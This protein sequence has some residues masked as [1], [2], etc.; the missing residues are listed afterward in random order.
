VYDP[1]ADEW[2]GLK[3]NDP[4]Y[5]H[6]LSTDFLD[7]IWL[8]NGRTS[9][10]GGSYF[11]DSDNFYGRRTLRQYTISTDTWTDLAARPSSGSSAW[12]EPDTHEF[13]LYNG[14]PQN[15]G[16]FLYT[17]QP[18][19]T[20]GGA[21]KQY[22]TDNYLRYTIA[23][24]TWDTSFID[25]DIPDFGTA[26]HT[27]Y[28]TDPI[29]GFA[30]QAGAGAWNTTG[31]TDGFATPVHDELVRNISVND[32]FEHDDLN[33][34]IGNAIGAYRNKILIVGALN[35][36]NEVTPL[37]YTQLRD[38]ALNTMTIVQDIPVKVAYAQ[39]A[40]INDKVYIMGGVTLHYNNWQTTHLV[41]V[42]DLLSFE[43]S[44]AKPLPRG[45]AYGRAVGIGNKIYLYGG[46]H[47]QSGTLS[48]QL[49]VYDTEESE[50]IVGIE[51]LKN[52]LLTV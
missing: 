14:T 24:N 36:S 4:L 49:I 3:E 40:A 52:Y 2:P 7:K 25:S 42:F 12:R 41:Q 19:D 27:A 17:N 10:D 39:Y 15:P 43:W 48:N 35:A 13:L 45:L 29:T 50:R 9:F 32:N 6:A 33:N 37:G 22:R 23:T 11:E 20:S 38:H 1:L 26:R 34:I 18:E 5:G 16:N 51:N 21:F 47:S 8:Y 28:A 31:S 30:W 46:R 44:F